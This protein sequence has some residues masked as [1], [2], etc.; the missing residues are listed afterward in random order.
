M[1]IF[2]FYLAQT[3]VK[4]ILPAWLRTLCQFDVTRRLA[5][6]QSHEVDCFRYVD[7][8]GLQVAKLMAIK[9]ELKIPQTD[10]GI[11]LG[12]KYIKANQK[13]T[14]E[15]AGK[16]KLQ[17]EKTPYAKRFLEPR[18]KEQEK[19]F[20][21][22]GFYNAPIF[23]EGTLNKSLPQLIKTLKKENR[24][25]DYSKYKGDKFLDFT[26]FGLKLITLKGKNGYTFIAKL[27]LNMMKIVQKGYDLIILQNIDEDQHPYKYL[28]KYLT[29]KNVDYI[30]LASARIL[31]EGSAKSSRFGGWEPYTVDKIIKRFSDFDLPDFRVGLRLYF[32]AFKNDFTRFEFKYDDLRQNI[33]FAKKACMFLAK[34]NADKITKDRVETNDENVKKMMHLLTDTKT[35]KQPSRIANAYKMFLG[36][37]KNAA[38]KGVDI[39]KEGYIYVL[40]SLRELLG[41]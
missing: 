1:K 8:T 5:I 16:V 12:H 23:W 15:E 36:Q 38:K 11:Y 40:N 20:E 33:V 28:E 10:V 30:T 26:D 3:P 31:L 34:F 32:L 25:L 35:L 17:L 18:I 6:K 39:E 7:E 13:V 14:K 4:P 21:V 37:T 29:L 41:G 19:F 27:L 24:L 2:I 22:L 9:S